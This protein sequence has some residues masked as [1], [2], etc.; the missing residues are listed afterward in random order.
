MLPAHLAEL[1]SIDVE[2]RIVNPRLSAFAFTPYER[3]VV[4]VGHVDAAQQG[5]REGAA[6]IFVNTFAD[7]GLEAMRAVLTIPVIGAGE[8][9]LQAAARGGRSFAIVTVWPRSLGYLYDER[10]RALALAEQCVAVRHVSPEEELG[11]VGR[12]DGVMERMHRGEPAIVEHLRLECERAVAEQG[13]ECIVLGCTCMAPIGPALEAACRVPVLEASRVGFR[14]ALAAVRM[15]AA[16]GPLAPIAHD[17]GLMPAL[18]DA[19][20]GRTAS[21][22]RDA[23]SGDCPVCVSGPPE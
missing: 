22:G 6:A 18:V 15:S 13:A 4:D 12:E 21:H 16:A 20:L 19:W 9:T 23:G 10:L 7:Y 3:L 1:A 11:H 8:A 5:E 2:P 17:P 14:A